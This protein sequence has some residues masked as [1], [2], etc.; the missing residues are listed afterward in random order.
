MTDFANRIQIRF[1]FIEHPRVSETEANGSMAI[2]A[3]LKVAR[4]EVGLAD[5]TLS[6]NFA[7]SR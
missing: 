2:S 3:L 5:C 1:D 4:T 7:L 6:A